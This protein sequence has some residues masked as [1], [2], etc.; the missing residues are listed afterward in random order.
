M[1]FSGLPAHRIR[2]RRTLL[3]KG[4]G[5]RAVA[6]NPEKLRLFASKGAEDVFS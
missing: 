2:N 3:A 1:S 4:E 6:R 5:V